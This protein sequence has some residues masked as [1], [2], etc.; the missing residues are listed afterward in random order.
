[1]RFAVFIDEAE[2]VIGQSHQM[3]AGESVMDSFLRLSRVYDI[4]VFA[5]N[6]TLSSLSPTARKTSGAKV[7]F[8][9]DDSE[10]RIAADAT[11]MTREQTERFRRMERGQ[12]LVKLDSRPQVPPFFARVPYVHIDRTVPQESIDAYFAGTITQLRSRVKLI[13]DRLKAQVRTLMYREPASPASVAPGTAHDGKLV[14][15]LTEIAANPFAMVKAHFAVLA[16][17]GALRR[18]EGYFAIQAEA[19]RLELVELYQLK[20]N[21]ETGRPGTFTALTEAGRRLLVDAGLRSANAPLV[22]GRGGYLHSLLVDTVLHRFAG[23]EGISCA[24]EVEGADLGVLRGS[25][26]LL[27]C[28]VAL[29]TTPEHEAFQNLTRDLANGWE[30]V[31]T[32]TAATRSVDGLTVLDHDKSAEKKQLIASLVDP[33]SP[34]RVLTFDE[35]RRSPVEL[36]R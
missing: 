17:D 22:P 10:V 31:L 2:R 6:Q 4:F 16:R 28:E 12:V 5:G 23:V 32:I 3:L 8:S 24:T 11:G 19:C 1:M 35:W 25:R 27:A 33:A 34:V 36:S 13:D 15:F 21:R 20:L 26:K 14:R 30:H 29:S 9:L 7:L 18:L